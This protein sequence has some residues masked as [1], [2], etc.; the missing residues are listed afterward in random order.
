MK[1]RQGATSLGSGFTIKPLDEDGIGSPKA[2]DPD[3]GGLRGKGRTP[4]RFG[5]G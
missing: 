1:D 5:A 3:T 2:I 4:R